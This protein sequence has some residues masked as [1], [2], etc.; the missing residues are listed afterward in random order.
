MPGGLVILADARCVGEID[1]YRG[2]IDT[3][4]SRSGARESF[5]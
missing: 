4:F 5:F 2:R 1:F 3:L